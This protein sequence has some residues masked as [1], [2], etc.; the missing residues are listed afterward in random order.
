MPARKALKG[1]AAQDLKMHQD[2][3]LDGG[4]PRGIEA[5]EVDEM[6]GQGP[7]LVAR[8]GGECRKQ[9]PLVDQAVLEGEQ[10]EEQV[11]R[12]VGRLRHGSGSQSQSVQGGTV[13][14]RPGR[15]GPY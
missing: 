7:A 8:P 4:S 2:D 6:V 15:A 14:L 9:P 10:A 12:G 13:P 3:G 1:V 5:A 11:T